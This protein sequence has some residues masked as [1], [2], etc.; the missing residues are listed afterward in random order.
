MKMKKKNRVKMKPMPRMPIMVTTKITMDENETELE[1]P[2]GYFVEGGAMH[3]LGRK[4][5]QGK[6]G[7][8]KRK[9]REQRKRKEE[10]SREKMK[11]KRHGSDKTK[12]GRWSRSGKSTRP[13]TT[14]GKPL[15]W[16]NNQGRAGHHR[17]RETL[18]VDSITRKL[19]TVR[20][21]CV[22]RGFDSG[23]RRPVRPVSCPDRRGAT[24]P[25]REQ[26][27][28]SAPREIPAGSR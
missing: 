3:K 7:E 1:N 6:Q 11:R 27:T 5:G 10:T 24:G 15:P 8:S 9:T 12:G 28:I 25:P 19:T 4:G 21:L 22:R 26:R 13:T 16:G 23:R 20:P 18:G 17:R 2:S 14:D